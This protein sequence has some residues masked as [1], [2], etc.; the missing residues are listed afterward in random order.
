MCGSSELSTKSAF[1]YPTVNW[2]LD[3][4]LI[5]IHYIAF[6]RILTKL[7]QNYSYSIFS[8]FCLV[9]YCCTF[10]LYDLYSH[11]SYSH[12]NELNK[13]N[14]NEIVTEKVT[15]IMNKKKKKITFI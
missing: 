15:H 9:L 7:L 13:L 11:Y 10:L 12:K 2:G 6:N 4:S 5:N 1:F 14:Q 3:D 8:P